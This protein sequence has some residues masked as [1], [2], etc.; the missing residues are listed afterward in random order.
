MK[1]LTRA[2]VSVL[3]IA[4]WRVHQG[5]GMPGWAGLLLWTFACVTMAEAWRDVEKF[6]AVDRAT[7][8]ALPL[9]RP[10]PTE[11]GSST[12]MQLPSV[13]EVP[14]LLSRL[15]RTAIE[16]SL[17]WPR[18]DYRLHAATEAS[19][20]SLEVRCTF[21]APYLQVRRFVTALLSDNPALTLRDFSVSRPSAEAGNVQAKLTLVIFL[22]GDVPA[23]ETR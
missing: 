21:D 19:P 4:L 15:E 7:P 10:T 3:K 17:G 13:S 23:E 22:A 14:M 5:W 20:A 1:G 16:K 6:E 18:A 12:R 8:V 11:T 9:A 2:A